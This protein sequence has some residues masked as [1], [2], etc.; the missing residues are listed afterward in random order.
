MILFVDDERKEID[1]FIL[2]LEHTFPQLI[3][4]PKVDAALML[5]NEKRDELKLLILDIMMPQGNAFKG[6]PDKG[7]RTGVHCYETV[8]KTLPELPIII[9]TNV[10]N[11]EVKKKFQPDSKCWFFNKEDYLPYELVEE[12]QGILMP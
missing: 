7:L 4:E 6:E 1:S 2:E 11:E 8:R 3:F 10:T 12:I 9:F 5:I